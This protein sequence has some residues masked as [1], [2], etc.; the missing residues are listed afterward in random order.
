MLDNL[1]NDDNEAARTKLCIL[2]PITVERV[3]VRVVFSSSIR[4]KAKLSYSR[5]VSAKTCARGLNPPAAETTDSYLFSFH[6]VQVC[7]FSNVPPWPTETDIWLLLYRQQLARNQHKRLC[8]PALFQ[9]HLPESQ[10]FTSLPPAEGSIMPADLH[11]GPR[12]GLQ[13]AP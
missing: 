6:L 8:P 2:A 9:L 13:R 5:T 1:T 3:F 11:D 12:S 7:F 10:R 4:R